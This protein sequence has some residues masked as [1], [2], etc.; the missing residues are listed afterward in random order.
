M[1]VKVRGLLLAKK[2]HAKRERANS[3]YSFTVAVMTGELIVS[4]KKFLQFAQCFYNKMS[5][6]SVKLRDPLL[7]D[8]AWFPQLVVPRLFLVEKRA[9][10]HWGGGGQSCLLPLRHATCDLQRPHPIFENYH[11]IFARACSL[12]SKWFSSEKS[13][14]KC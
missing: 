14:T 3:E 5:Q 13:N 2:S 7:D 12:F 4:R 1:L 9:W 10:Q 11:V 8:N 6:F